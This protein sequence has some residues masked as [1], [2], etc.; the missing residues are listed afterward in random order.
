LAI[1]V[2]TRPGRAIKI[3]RSGQFPDRPPFRTQ[4]GVLIFENRV[5]RDSHSPRS[6]LSL[7]SSSP[8]PAPSSSPEVTCS[9]NRRKEGGV[10]PLLSRDAQL[11]PMVLDCR[12]L[13]IYIEWERVSFFDCAL[14]RTAMLIG[15][16]SLRNRW[17]GRE[18]KTLSLFDGILRFLGAVYASSYQVRR[19]GS[20]FSFVIRYFPWSTS[21]C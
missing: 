15:V 3:W 13:L 21:L 12:V 4:S 17:K 9:Q 6:L 20:G 18:E 11:V 7:S 19:Q 5:G 1:G 16:D 10:E 8:I 14:P 2:L